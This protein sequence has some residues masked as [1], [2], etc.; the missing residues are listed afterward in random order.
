MASLD[1][2]IVAKY[3]PAQA[4]AQAAATKPP[5]ATVKPAVTAKKSASPQLPK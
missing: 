3:L 5:V 2:A 1:P 4:A